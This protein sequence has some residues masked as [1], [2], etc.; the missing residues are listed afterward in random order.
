[1]IKNNYKRNDISQNVDDERFTPNWHTEIL[2]ELETK[3]K[4]NQLKF[5]NFD[6]AKKRLQS[7]AIAG[8]HHS[9]PKIIHKNSE[10][11]KQL[12]RKFKQ[13]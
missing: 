5:S 11:S 7:R 13:L 10:N 9:I 8:F 3:E 12:F 4:D 6:D 1:M 2:D